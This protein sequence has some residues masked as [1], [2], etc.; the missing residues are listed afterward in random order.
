M[1]AIGLGSSPARC[2][3]AAKRGECI[4]DGKRHATGMDRI[5]VTVDVKGFNA[6]E[7]ATELQ[8]A[9]DQQASKGPGQVVSI[10]MNANVAILLMDVVKP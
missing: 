1:A 8:T 9:L 10:A 4:G 2:G 6:D 7:V 5:L 3:R